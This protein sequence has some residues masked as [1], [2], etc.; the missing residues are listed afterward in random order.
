MIENTILEVF[1]V[2]AEMTEYFVESVRSSGQV[3]SIKKQ[4]NVDYLYREKMEIFDV[5]VI[6]IEILLRID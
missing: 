4:I 2:F 6:G 1:C 3:R 5:L